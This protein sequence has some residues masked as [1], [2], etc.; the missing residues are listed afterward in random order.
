V[1]RA[2]RFPQH[3]NRIPESRTVSSSVIKPTRSQK[4][5][6]AK[7]GAVNG[8]GKL[9]NVTERPPI[10]SELPSLHDFT[11]KSYRGG[12][13]RFYLPLLYDLVAVEKPRLV[14]TIG[15]DE[16]DAFFT[17]C[18]AAQEKRID[19]HCIAIR[20]EEGQE[21]DDA[22]WQAGRAYGQEFYGEAVQFFSGSWTDLVKNFANEQVDLLVIDECD[23][24]LILERDLSFW[25]PRL[26]AGAV[27]VV[28]GIGV[29]R[30]DSPGRAW[31]EFISHR[32][33][34]EFNEGIGLG[35]ALAG[36][37]AKGESILRAQLFGSERTLAA[38]Y[39]LGAARI[40]AQQ[41]IAHKERENAALQARQIW[42]DSVLGDRWKAQEVMDH[43]ARTISDLQNQF[44]NAQKIADAQAEQ[45]KQIRKTA[46]ALTS[47]KKKLQT[48]VAEQKRVLDSIPHKVLR[49]IERIPRNLGK[50]WARRK[51]RPKKVEGKTV[52]PVERYAAWIATHEPNV[53]ELDQQREEARSWANPPKISL[54]VPVFNPSPEFLKAML[55]SIHA[56]TYENWEIC[57]A[58]AS[59]GGESAAEI[60]KTWQAREPRVRLQRLER[61]LGISENTNHALSLATGDFVAC[62]DQDDL[63]APF[64]LYELTK[65]IRESPDTEIFYSD[66]DRWSQKG[67]RQSP[68]FKPEWSPELLQSFMY[69]GHLTAYRRDLVE[70][71]GGFRKEFDLSQDYD[72][73]LRATERAHAIKHIP[74]VLYHWREHAASG[75][76][77]GKPEARKTNLAALRD[78][79]QRR[80]LNA[81]VIEHPTANRARMKVTN[82]PR[83]SIIIPTDSASRA[84]VCVRELPRET[85]YPALELVLVTNSAL[86]AAVSKKLPADINVQF[87]PFDQPFNFSAKC[88]RGAGA[89]N[90]ERL[91]FL[92]DDVETGQRDW[93]QNL[94]EPLE[95]PG[96]GAVAPKMTYGSGK[97]QHA[98]LVMGVRGLI[99]TAFHEWDA[100]SVDYFNLAQSMRNVSVLSGA[101][102][103]M[104]REDFFRLGG[105]DEINTP[106]SN[107]DTDLCFKIRR[108]GKRCVYTPFVTMIHRGHVSIG[109][110]DGKSLARGRDKSSIFLLKRWAD[111][112]CR[113]PYYTENMRDWLYAD[114]PTPIRMFAPRISPLP[115]SSHDLLFVSHDLTWSGAPI[116]LLHAAMW[117]REHGIFVVV[118][119]PED[120]PLRER[121]LE[122][123]IPVIV[124]PLV[125]TGHASF[126]NFARDFDCLVASTIFGAPAIDAAQREAIPHIWWI[127]EGLVGEHYLRR[128]VKLRNTV[129]L[130]EFI[131]APDT[132]SSSIYQPFASRPIRRLV[133]G[134]PDVAQKFGPQPR[135]GE[136]LRF[137]LLGTIEHRKGQEVFLEA[138][139]KLPGNVLERAHFYIVG[140]PNDLKITRQIEAAAAACPSLNFRSYVTHD[141]ALILIRDADVMVSA[142]WDETGPLTLMEGMAMGKAILSTNVGC[143]G[144]KLRA[145]EDGLFFKPGDARRLADAIERLVREPGLLEKLERNSR[146]AYEKHFT[147]D[148]FGSD[149][150]RLVEEVI[151][152]AQAQSETAGTSAGSSEV[153]AAVR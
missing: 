7:L 36:E 57:I 151:S 71:L 103:A 22:V 54:V 95:S 128:D 80:G 12:P 38:I 76:L 136:P 127:H 78:A 34:V 11:P 24:G 111:F 133:Y 58:G 51:V 65:A 146:K 120:G 144:E 113:D 125:A 109:D 147:L 121:F 18:Q 64:A 32:P 89:A 134:I 13:I 90:G 135:K 79:M 101:C 73:A 42:L 26:A 6:G 17:F 138:L 67:M 143:V 52:P 130:A 69:L 84:E 14:V 20:R 119:S 149:F 141:D 16:G 25:K 98:G 129:G 153:V 37:Q 123:G 2:T 122:A 131:V 5:S 59:S 92:N 102:L 45:L 8:R 152:S 3:L 87:I 40:G 56:Q 77:G 100:G 23:S 85:N 53:R 96:V 39:S 91:I 41:R 124:D 81:E 74:H 108:D 97:I 116:I 83:V 68:F 88:N 70:T 44:D 115:A 75:N 62:V 105:F 49:E 31:T 35:V 132:H 46:A 33:H 112:T 139:Q 19:C 99:G 43:Q 66:E 126:A 93:V 145:D 50:L 140:R 117:C 107:S 104:R 21:S 118:M 47:Q 28:H 137:L 1:N 10:L 60:L 142:S 114:S 82:W 61:N 48:Q 27:I 110:S 94:I 106:I 9:R 4:K 86:I 30:A 148:R 63:L 15:F 55:D 150:L 29:E 72:F